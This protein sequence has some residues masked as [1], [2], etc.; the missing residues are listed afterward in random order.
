LSGALYI[1]LASAFAVPIAGLM[2]D[3]LARR[4]PAGRMAVQ[5][6]GLLIGAFF[7][8]LVGK[9]GSMATLLLSMTLFGL[10]KG[11]YDSGIFASVYD[12]IDPRARGTAAGLVNTVGWGGGAL[13]P[14]FVGWACKHGSKSTDAE[15]M[16]DAIA[17]GGAIYI[18]AAVLII[19]AMILFS[20]RVSV[21]SGNTL[22]SG[23]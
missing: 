13:G 22:S 1:H 10:C 18:A 9:T 2:A 21:V 20:R 6:S 5:A 16:S 7:V 14:L 23:A 8:F 19:L 15:N 12:S 11:F 17:L 3:R 4:Y